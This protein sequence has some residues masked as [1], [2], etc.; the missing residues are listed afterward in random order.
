MGERNGRVDLEDRTEEEEEEE[1]K[2]REG[3]WEGKGK[4]ENRRWERGKEG[5]V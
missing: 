1:Q 4:E 2:R 5:I 3:Y